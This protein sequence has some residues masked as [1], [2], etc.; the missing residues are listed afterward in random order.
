MEMLLKWWK[1]TSQEQFPAIGTTAE[2]FYSH[3]NPSKPYAM[4]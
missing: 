4:A 1:D 3:H 2:R